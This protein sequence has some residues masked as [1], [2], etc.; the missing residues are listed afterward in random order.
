MEG[1]SGGKIIRKSIVTV[2]ASL[3]CLLAYQLSAEITVDFIS[4]E[5]MRPDVVPCFGMGYGTIGIDPEDNIYALWCGDCKLCK[6]N[7]NTTF[8]NCALFK[9]NPDTEERWLLGTL[10]ETAAAAGNLGPNQYWN[11]TE[12]F[13]KGHTHLPYQNG[14]IYIGT[15][16][17]HSMAGMRSDLPDYRGGHI[18]AYDIASD[19]LMDMSVSQPK[20]VFIDNQGII[21]LWDYAPGDLILGWTIPRGDIIMYNTKTGESNIKPGID[22][23]VVK[24]NEPVREFIVT[25]QGQI[26]YNYRNGPVYKYDMNTG[27]DVPTEYY[28]ENGG[29]SWDM[30]GFWNGLAMPKHSKKIY[31][32]TYGYLYEL[33]TET[34]VFT[35]LTWMLPESEDLH[36]CRTWGLATSLDEKKLY[37]I[38]TNGS[39][40]WRLYEYDIESNTVMFLKDLSYLINKNQTIRPPAFLSEVSGDNITDSKGRIYFVRHT[41]DNTGGSGILKIDV[42]ERSG[43]APSDETGVEYSKRDYGSYAASGRENLKITRSGSSVIVSLSAVGKFPYELY[44][45]GGKVIAEGIIEGGKAS[46]LAD[47]GVSG[48]YILRV[49]GGNSV[50]TAKVFKTGY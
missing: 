41:Y 46:V 47:P 40:A 15:Q 17:F 20:G 32:S 24:A 21:Q 6:T 12:I 23:E 39:A 4:F 27:E 45:P 11:K 38:P 2:S 1:C 8:G 26:Y 36:I 18:F 37:W 50:Y 13:M 49:A 29:C 14:R 28:M 34:G 31:V 43:P 7:C 48:I 10:R 25:P 5:D 33:D 42:S 19:S 9:Y 16:E 22:S 30:W 35:F 44:D 3:I